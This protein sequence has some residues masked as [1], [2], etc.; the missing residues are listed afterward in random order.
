MTSSTPRGGGGGGGSRTVKKRPPL[1]LY[2]SPIN[3]FRK[4]LGRDGTIYE[5]KIRT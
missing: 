4:A 2:I 3:F 5:D 1:N